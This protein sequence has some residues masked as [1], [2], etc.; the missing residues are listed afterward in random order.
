[1]KK[2]LFIA[3]LIISQV[4]FAQKRI[5]R[6]EVK[7]MTVAEARASV[8][9]SNIY[10][11][12]EKARAAGK[13]I[14][15]DKQVGPK[16]LRVVSGLLTTHT[17]LPK[18]DANKVIGLL[19]ASP[20]EVMSEITRLTSTIGDKNSSANE[21]AQAKRNLELIVEA[22]NTIDSLPVNNAAALKEQAKIKSILQ[23]SEKISKLNLGEKSE[24]F[25]SKYKQALA[26]GKTVEQAVKIASNGKFTEKELRSCSI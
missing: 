13:D 7:R 18:T 16:I 6:P 21:V 9:K 4:S 20:L 26:E 1:M 12:I 14:L 17:N 3:A 24:Q 19:N 10:K 11:E 5:V 8:E 2:S 22:S 15:A 25:I 23:M